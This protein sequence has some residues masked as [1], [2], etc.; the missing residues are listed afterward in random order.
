M[1]ATPTTT[2]TILGSETS[3]SDYGDVL[4]SETPAGTGIPANILEGRQVVATE[5]DQ[6]AR[7]IRYYTGRL[8][9]GTVVTGN[10]RLRDDVTGDVYV[11]DNV[12][13]PANPVIPQDVRLDLRRV[14]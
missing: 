9:Y 13:R 6:Q 5:S 1:I 3:Q 12:S 11:I 10:N 4:D 2:V 7:V 8:P 14:T